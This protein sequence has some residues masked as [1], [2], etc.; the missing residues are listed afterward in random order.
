[1]IFARFRHFRRSDCE[2]REQSDRRT[3]L[4][5]LVARPAFSLSEFTLPKGRPFSSTS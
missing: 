5:S 1:M 4:K 2:P 3:F